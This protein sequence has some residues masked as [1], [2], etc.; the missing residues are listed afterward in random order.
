MKQLVSFPILAAAAFLGFTA[1]ASA[2]SNDVTVAAGGDIAKCGASGDEQTAELVKTLNPTRVVTLGDNVYPDGTIWEFLKCYN[3]SWGAFKAK[4]KPSPGNHDYHTPAARGYGEY[5]SRLD[6]PWYA[7][8]LRGWRFYSLNSE[9]RIE[10]QADWLRNDMEGHPRIATSPT[11]TGPVT[12]M[13]ST[14]LLRR[15]HGGCQAHA[16]PR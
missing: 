13:G 8:N 9:E 14:A 10:E 6:D 7:W 5:F 3:P 1:S 12:A 2:L 11:G 4:T 16:D 15:W